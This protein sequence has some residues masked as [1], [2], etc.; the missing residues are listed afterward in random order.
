MVVSKGNMFILNGIFFIL[1]SLF[2]VLMFINFEFLKIVFGS[3]IERGKYIVFMLVFRGYKC[4]RI[5]FFL[6]FFNNGL[7][8]L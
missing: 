5:L 8:S 6:I 2:N 4:N 3:S 1:L 7:N